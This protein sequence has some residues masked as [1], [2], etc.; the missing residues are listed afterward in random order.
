VVEPRT[1]KEDEERIVVLIIRKATE[2]DSQAKVKKMT[3]RT[4]KRRKRRKRK[5]K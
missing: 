1:A 5:K 3:M 4:M 2:K